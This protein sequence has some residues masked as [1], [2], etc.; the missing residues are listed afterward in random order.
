MLSSGKAVRAHARGLWL[1]SQILLAIQILSFGHLLSSRHVTCLEH[2]DIIHLRHAEAA[3]PGT[4][5]PN[6][7]GDGRHSM[8]AES[9]VEAE[10]DHCLVC[11]DASRRYLLIGPAQPMVVPQILASSVRT[12]RSAFFTP[13][14]LLLLSPKNSPPLA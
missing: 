10:H 14:D 4:P 3:A 8:A 9:S 5:D 11:A 2:G 1:A 12:A 6:A 13:V 7:R